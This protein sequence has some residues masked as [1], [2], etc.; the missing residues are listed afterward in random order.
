MATE[1][2]AAGWKA[3]DVLQVLARLFVG[4]NLLYYAAGKVSDPA[5]FLKSVREYAILPEDP[6]F[7]L[8]SVAVL[9]PWIELVGGLCLVLGLLR[10]GVAT[11][12]TA[13]LVVFT[14][15][16]LI[17][18]FEIHAAGELGFCEIVFDCGCGSGEVRICDKL[19]YNGLLIALSAF[20]VW[21]PSDKLTLPGRRPGA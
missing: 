21:S 9:V 18:T 20:L 13:M 10:R 11:V 4:G 1:T 3:G 16:I 6:P 17:R 19:V 15:A 2:P 12:V 8:N 5:I 14:T 7:L